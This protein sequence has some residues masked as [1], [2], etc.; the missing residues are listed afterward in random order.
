MQATIPH[1]RE[2]DCIASPSAVEGKNCQG[3]AKF[4]GVYYSSQNHQ[5]R[6]LRT[7]AA[8]LVQA[9]RYAAKTST[10]SKAKS[11]PINSCREL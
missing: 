11:I 7:A 1:T 10:P 8:P 4:Q 3:P 2:P 9:Q 6:A 5:L